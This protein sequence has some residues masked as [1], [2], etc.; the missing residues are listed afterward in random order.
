MLNDLGQ[1][2]SYPAILARKHE[3]RGPTDESNWVIPDRLLVGAY[4][5]EAEDDAEHIQILRGILALGIS[6][7]VCLQE[8]YVHKM[9][10]APT[11]WKAGRV[12]RPYIFDAAELCKHPPV[13]PSGERYPRPEQLRLLHVPIRDF[14]CSNDEVVMRLAKAL[15]WRLR[16]GEKVYLH[17]WGGHGRT[18]T[19]TAVLLGIL[20]DL[21]ATDALRRTQFFHDL[22]VNTLHVGSPQTPEQCLQVVR[23][24]DA[25]RSA[26]SAN[27]K[28]IHEDLC[29][30]F[31][32]PIDPGQICANDDGTEPRGTVHKML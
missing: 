3:Y 27:A 32:L 8:E 25:M 29:S 22:R 28:Q 11:D 19:V 5:G 24:L 26:E 30:L 7:F 23:V 2:P 12:C 13:G 4:P 31:Q 6:T 18:G 14:D 15:I 17:C 21:T 10:I 16:R 1:L 9:D 20:Y